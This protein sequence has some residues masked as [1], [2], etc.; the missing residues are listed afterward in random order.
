[1]RKLI[2]YR[3]YPK[4]KADNEFE[5]SRYDKYKVVT[6]NWTYAT[7]TH[8]KYKGIKK[9]NMVHKNEYVFTLAELIDFI[10]RTVEV[11]ED[12]IRIELFQQEI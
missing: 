1:M 10:R 12:I 8:G 11:C 9:F 7:I 5:S 4:K 2:H 6:I 3:H